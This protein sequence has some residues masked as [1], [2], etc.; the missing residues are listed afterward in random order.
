MEN[1][2]HKYNVEKISI[3]H[4][5]NK[6]INKVKRNNFNYETSCSS[7]NNKLSDKGTIDVLKDYNLR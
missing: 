6:I 3:E 7:N 2:D 5:D 4:T 1:E